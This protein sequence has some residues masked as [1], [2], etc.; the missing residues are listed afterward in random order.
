MSTDEKIEKGQQT[1]EKT[2]REIDLEKLQEVH[3]SETKVSSALQTGK[4]SGMYM[5]PMYLKEKKLSRKQ[6]LNT[7]QRVI[8]TKVS[9]GE[10]VKLPKKF[11]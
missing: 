7:Y 5:N 9:G 1:P 8:P 4:T 10:F 6:D 11:K 3:T 2:R